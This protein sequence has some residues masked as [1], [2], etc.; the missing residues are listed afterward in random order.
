MRGRRPRPPLE[1]LTPRHGKFLTTFCL[2]LPPSLPPSLFA[3]SCDGTR[4]E[5]HGKQNSTIFRDFCYVSFYFLMDRFLSHSCMSQ[6]TRCV[7]LDSH[8]RHASLGSSYLIAHVLHYP[9]HVNSF[10]IGSAVINNNI[11]TNCLES[12]IYVASRYSNAFVPRGCARK[13]GVRRVQHTLTA[14]LL[15][16]MLRLRLERPGSWSASSLHCVTQDARS[17]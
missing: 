11:L 2:S 10:V 1:C 14:A 7:N 13:T 4:G 16:N 17:R 12:N 3:A 9:P 8:C 6:C 5:A 15:C